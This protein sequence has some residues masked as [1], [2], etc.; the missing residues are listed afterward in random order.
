MAPSKPFMYQLG[1]DCRTSRKSGVQLS[2]ISQQIS[3]FSRDILQNATSVFVCGIGDM[4]D[5]ANVVEGL[6]LSPAA[7]RIVQTSLNGP[8][9]SGA[10]FLAFMRMKDGVYEQHL[11]NTLGPIELWAFSTSS[12]DAE[13][14][15]RLYEKLGPIRARQR[16]AAIFPG[17]TAEDELEKRTQSMIETGLSKDTADSSVMDEIANEI[18]NCKGIAAH[19]RG[20]GNMENDVVT[21]YDWAKLLPAGVKAAPQSIL[22]NLYDE[23]L[24]PN[25]VTAD[26]IRMRQAPKR[27]V[28]RPHADLIRAGAE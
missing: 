16:L 12:K 10:P 13:L 21:Y 2:F 19:L 14:R 26:T 5:F 11:V 27:P 1:L 17:G 9:S 22:M 6:G 28:N 18:I 4:T 23:G 8:T 24:E 7:G 20:Q 25:D 15:H 3:D